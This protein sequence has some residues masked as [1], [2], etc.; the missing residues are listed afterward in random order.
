MSSESRV[1]SHLNLQGNAEVRNAVLRSTAFVALSSPPSAPAIGEVYF[2]LTVSALKVWTGSSWQTLS[3][4]AEPISDATIFGTGLD[5]D[6]TISGNT[7]LSGNK[8]YNNLTI[9]SGVSL[10]TNGWQ[11]FVAGTLTLGNG[12]RIHCN[13]NAASGSTAGTARSS[14]GFYGF[15]GAGQTGIN[16]TGGSAAQVSNCVGSTGGN[17]G[18]ASAGSNWGGSGGLASPVGA[19]DGGKNAFFLVA[20]MQTGRVVTGANGGKFNGG[21]GGG[22]GFG[23]G[24]YAGAGGGGGAGICVVFAF[25]IVLSGSATISA[26]GGTGGN[27]ASGNAGGGGGGGGGA[28]AVISKYAQPSGLTVSADGGVGGN[29][30]GT[31]QTGQ[32]GTAGIA[33]FVVTA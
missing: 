7:T 22:A 30:F 1:L 27:G 9:A 21:T 3:A 18:Y 15:G 19:T 23:N 2:D 14:A 24:L 13:G 4:L 12:A 10:D 26:N 32:T 8:H 25:K 6:A 33:K 29:G 5:G 17:G 11:L 28:C 16:N 20:S 31:G